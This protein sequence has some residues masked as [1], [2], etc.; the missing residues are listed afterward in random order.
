MEE[1]CGSFMIFAEELATFARHKGGAQK[2]GVKKMQGV[3]HDGVGKDVIPTVAK[4]AED[5]A[6]LGT[7][8]GL[9]GCQQRGVTL[10]A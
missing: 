1:P 10:A 3:G 7:A 9:T 4:F 6:R 8:T 5:A 2:S